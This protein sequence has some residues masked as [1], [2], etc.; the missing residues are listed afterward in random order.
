MLS[1]KFHDCNFLIDL[2]RRVHNIAWYRKAKQPVNM[3]AQVEA[4]SKAVIEGAFE[5]FHN[6]AWLSLL[7][8]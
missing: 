4:D 1:N 2:L 7:I 5:S 8:L 6:S 3:V